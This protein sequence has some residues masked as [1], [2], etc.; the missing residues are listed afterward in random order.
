[1]DHSLADCY[2]V[3]PN[4]DD[5]VTTG[6]LVSL[7]C[8]AW[9]EGAKWETKA[10]KNAVHE[11]NFLKL[12]CSKIKSRL[13]WYPIWNI[14]NAVSNTVEWSKAWLAGESVSDVMDRQI[15]KYFGF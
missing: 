12:D 13:G 4:E 2:N 14:D 7:F 1:M 5:C 15:K 8:E 11:A 10:E 9:G 3:G 6:K